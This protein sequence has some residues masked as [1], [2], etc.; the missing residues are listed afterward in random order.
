MQITLTGEVFQ[1]LGRPPTA[2]SKLIPSSTTKAATKANFV[3]AVSFPSFS[4]SSLLSPSSALQTGNP[5]QPES[6]SIGKD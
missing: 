4:L 3:T 6:I 1:D 5:P 2:I